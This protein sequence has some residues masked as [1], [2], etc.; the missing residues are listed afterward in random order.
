MLWLKFAFL[1]AEGIMLSDLMN[2][3]PEIYMVEKKWNVKRKAR[4]GYSLYNG[5]CKK[6]KRKIEL[7]EGVKIIMTK[8][9]CLL[10]LIPRSLYAR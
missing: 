4:E 5:Y 9:G 3:I 7:D 6:A 2:E 10:F 1:F 8:D